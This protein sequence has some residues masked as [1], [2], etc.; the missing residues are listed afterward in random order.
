MNLTTYRPRTFFDDTFFD[1]FFPSRFY[2]D[3][4]TRKPNARVEDGD[5]AIT[6]QLELPGVDKKDIDVK[7]ENSV[8]TITAK[9]SQEDKSEKENVYYNEISY[10]EYTRSFKL[11]DDVKSDDVK[12]NLK[13]G[14]LTLELAKKEQA[15]PRQIKIQ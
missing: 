10:G 15:L 4:S 2:N 5:K 13:A 14:V 11:S 1:G 8:L 7:V 9:K 6:V 3:V 12:A